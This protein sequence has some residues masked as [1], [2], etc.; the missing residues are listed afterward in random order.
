MFLK[1]PSD[2]LLVPK[3]CLLKK[4]KEYSKEEAEDKEKIFVNG[5]RW[6][7]TRLDGKEERRLPKVTVRTFNSPQQLHT[8]LKLKTFSPNLFDHRN[9]NYQYIFVPSIS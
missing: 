5:S 9:T 1:N 6:A 3:A 7:V 4:K 2:D 8:A